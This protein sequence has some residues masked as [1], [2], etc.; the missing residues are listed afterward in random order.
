MATPKNLFLNVHQDP[1]GR[2]WGVA[3]LC[4]A[5]GSCLVVES[6]IYREQSQEAGPTSYR[7]QYAAG[8]DEDET[9]PPKNK[10]LDEALDKLCRITKNKV[11][12]RAIPLPGRLAL[13]AVCTAR[14]LMKIKRAAEQDGD[15][16]ER[17]EAAGALRRMGTHQKETVRRAHKALRLW[18]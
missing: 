14:N 16:D 15:D 2:I 10:A 18:Q 13:K 17:E 12:M 9:E 8:E 3:R 7:G 1:D 5:D 4:M 11:I 6:R